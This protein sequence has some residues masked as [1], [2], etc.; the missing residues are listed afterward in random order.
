M[1]PI[2]ALAGV[3][4]RYARVSALIHD[5][6]WLIL[7]EPTTGVD[8]LSRQQFWDLIA[9]IRGQRPEMSVIV[10]TAYMEEAG[11]FD[12]LTAM[13][14]GRVIATGTSAEIRAN[15]GQ[16]TLEK[17]FI[18]ML[19]EAAHRGHRDV[20]VPP[21]RPT[22]GPPAIEAKS[23]SRDF[24]AVDVANFEI[25]RGET[26]GSL[27]SNGCGKTA[28]MK[29]L[30]GLLPA[31]KGQAL[32]FGESL[33]VGDMRT[34]SRVGHMS[35]SFSL[36]TEQTVRQNLDLHA[37]LYQLP[38]SKRAGRVAEII[39]KFHLAE[40]VDARPDALPLGIR[41]R[42][43]LAVAIIHSPEVLIL[44]APSSGVDPVAR[45]AFWQHLIALSR[46]DGVT[47]FISTHFMNEAQ[48]CDSISLMHAV[49][50]LAGGTR[51]EIAQST[52]TENLSD[53]FVDCLRAAIVDRAP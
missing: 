51:A 18:A 15:A 30:T 8:P 52:N 32:F 12:W 46:E 27:G 44:D 37:D 1:P 25:E 33:D 16:P 23:L 42:L 49:R 43:Q 11:E 14:D 21:W 38:A 50:V 31:S 7:D 47:I 29:M 22:D 24:T 5:P 26:V 48:R 17:A 13:S 2:G 34:R 35:Q 41:Q 39:Q 19:P 9:H 45:D 53:A 4:H 3:T 28:T 10:A 40:V 36:N 6:D 20:V